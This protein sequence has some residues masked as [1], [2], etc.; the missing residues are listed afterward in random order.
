VPE[1]DQTV[2][3]AKTTAVPEVPTAGRSTVQPVAFHQL[4]AMA[5]DDEQREVD[6]DREPE[7]DAEPGVT[8]TM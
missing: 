6:A 2:E 4:A 8:E 3:P 5:V 1:G 7:H